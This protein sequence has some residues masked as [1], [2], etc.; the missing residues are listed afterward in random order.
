MVF[1]ENGASKRW[2]CWSQRVSTLQFKI[3]SQRADV[4]HK[5]S[6]ALA[7]GCDV[8]GIGHWEPEREVS[9]RKNLGPQR[10]K[11]DWGLQVQPKN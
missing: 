6:R 5:I 10:K 11:L 2:K 8:V 4:L 7:E 3:A 9:Y 1:R